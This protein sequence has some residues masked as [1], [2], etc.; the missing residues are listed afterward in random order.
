MSVLEIGLAIAL[1]LTCGLLFR[2]YCKHLI[3][4]HMFIHSSDWNARKVEEVAKS[5]TDQI[6]RIA[7]DHAAERGQQLSEREARGWV[8]GLDRLPALFNV[9]RGELILFGARN[10][11]G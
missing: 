8:M 9:L 7:I 5:A 3:L 4:R 6:I 1:V 10:P 11:K 2:L